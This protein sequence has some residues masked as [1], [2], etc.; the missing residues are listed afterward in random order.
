MPRPGPAPVSRSP[1][2]Q[3][4]LRLDR[5]ASVSAE[6][7]E[8]I[9]YYSSLAS[10]FGKLAKRLRWSVLA[11]WVVT[12]ALSAAFWRHAFHYAASL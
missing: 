2:M 6:F 1:G 10:R 9:N 3:P 7:S 12:L 8:M 4:Y 5:R 11:T